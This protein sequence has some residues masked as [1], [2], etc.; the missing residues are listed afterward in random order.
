MMTLHQREIVEVSFPMPDGEVLIHPALVLS[1]EDL[2]SEED[3]LF[4]A[5]LISSKNR[6]SE[7][8]LPIHDN[9]LSKPL[10][11]QSYFVTH[12]V[13]AFKPE[14]VTQRYNNYIK[15]APFDQVLSKI[16]SS[17]FDLEIEL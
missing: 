1:G 13:S 7:F 12:L 16:L 14:H 2:Q 17:M 5:V 4:Y 10:S 6:H 3:G 11:K 9:W 15:E 8:A